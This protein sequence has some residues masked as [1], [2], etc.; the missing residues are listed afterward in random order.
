MKQSMATGVW[1]MESDVVSGRG[2]FLFC[3]AFKNRKC[4]GTF[5]ADEN[6]PIERK[7]LAVQEK[8]NNSRRQVLECAGGK[9]IIQCTC[10]AG[11]RHGQLW[12]P[13]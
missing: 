2:F 11:T 4:Y 9:R 1:F 12:A 10:G 13:D 6:E 5:V 8:K 7:K 3:F